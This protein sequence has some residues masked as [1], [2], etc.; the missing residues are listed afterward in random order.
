MEI[1]KVKQMFCYALFI[2]VFILFEQILMNVVQDNIFVTITPS[3]ST[4]R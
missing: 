1:V 2:N 4:T 3:V